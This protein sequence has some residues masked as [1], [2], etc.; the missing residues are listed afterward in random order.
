MI[1]LGIV[2]NAKNVMEVMMSEWGKWDRIY[3]S[4]KQIMKAREREVSKN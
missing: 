3:N 2:L 1:D 4:I